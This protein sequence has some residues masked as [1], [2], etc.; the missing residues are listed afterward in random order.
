[1]SDLNKLISLC[2]ASITIEI[3]D[4]KT[5]YQTVR[6]W[7]LDMINR[8]EIQPDDIPPE[9]FAEMEKRDTVISIH[10]YPD[11]PVGFYRIFHYDM[12]EA[13][14]LALSTFN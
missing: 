7:A 13:I 6:E 9:I 14:K 8:M 11:T 3:N 1:M 5:Y 2:K 4:H 10:F 12:D